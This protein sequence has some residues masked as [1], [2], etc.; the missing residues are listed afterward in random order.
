MKEVYPQ[1]FIYLAAFGLMDLV[2]DEFK[3]KNKYVLII[4]LLLGIIGYMN[5]K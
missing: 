2:I 4:Y 1:L 3:I 5:Y